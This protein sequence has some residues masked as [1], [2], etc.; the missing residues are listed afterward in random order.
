M[1]SDR[2]AR[3]DAYVAKARA[4]LAGLAS[5]GVC[6]SGNS[7]SSV[8]FVKGQLNAGEKDGRPLLSGEDGTALRKSLEALGYAPE[9]WAAVSCSLDTGKPLPA[10]TLRRAVAVLD[11]ATLVLCDEAAAAAV[12]EAYADELAALPDFAEAM[13]APGV[14]ALVLG[15]RVLNLGGFEAALADKQQKQ[16]MWARLKRVPPLGEP[17]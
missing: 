4:E 6:M 1:P 8:L 15:M 16:V 7:F 5:R 13:L 14:V 2:E 17:I 11:P 10:E 9:D 12:R 3:R